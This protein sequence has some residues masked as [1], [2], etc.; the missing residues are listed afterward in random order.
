MEKK[1]INEAQFRKLV[2]EEAKKFISEEANTDLE[3][4]SAAKQ[5]FSVL[6]KYNLK[7]QYEVDGEEFLSKQQVEGYGARI[8]LDN[9]GILTVAVYDRGIWGTLKQ[10]AQAPSTSTALAELDMGNVS[11]PSPEERKQIEQV[12]GNIYK[13]IVSTLGQDKFEIRSNP[14]PDKFGNYVIQIRKKESSVSAQA[15]QQVAERRI[16]FDKV[17]TLINEMENM[18]KSISSLSLDLDSK[19]VVEEGVS[20]KPNRDLDVVEHNKKKNITHVNEGEKDKWNRMLNYQV[21]SDDER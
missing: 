17:E 9:N 13:D 10:K 1:T 14:Q 3:L 4:K 12:A 20:A 6:K 19:K 11:H 16:T 7:P 8:V 2:I 5:M 18:N 15:P 21:P